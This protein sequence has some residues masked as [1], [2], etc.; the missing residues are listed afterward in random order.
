[1]LPLTDKPD[2]SPY[3]AEEDADLWSQKPPPPKGE[4]QLSV[5]AIGVR[6]EPNDPSGTYSVRARVVDKVS[7]ATVELTRTFVVDP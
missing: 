7:H 5:G 6:I 1:M 4:L 3:D 2:G